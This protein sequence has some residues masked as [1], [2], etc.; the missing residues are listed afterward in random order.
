M[1]LG[2]WIT[3][4]LVILLTALV[5]F[6]DYK[7]EKKEGGKSH[8]I[9]NSLLFSV[10]FSVLGMFL[11]F[12]VLGIVADYKTVEIIEDEPVEIS[13]IKFEDEGILPL[14]VDSSNTIVI[15][16]LF[17]DSGISYID[18]EKGVVEELSTGNITFVVDDSVKK[19]TIQKSAF[20]FKEGWRKYFSSEIDAY[21]VITLPEE[22]LEPLM[23]K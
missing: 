16:H 12:I 15:P 19:P 9:L 8:V 4:A 22:I 14:Q 5:V 23:N 10:M 18:E 20:Y 3:I 11:Y 17:E 1:Y 7:L 21:Y 6:V 13:H 2:V